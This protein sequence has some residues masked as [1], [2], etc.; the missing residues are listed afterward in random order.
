MWMVTMW[1][2]LIASELSI[3][4]KK[5]KSLQATEIS[6][7]IFLENKHMIQKMCGYFCIGFVDFMPKGKSLLKHTN[8]FSP[9]E[10]EKND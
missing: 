5:L 10:Y 3:F 6:Q 7:Q 9:D 2:I 8:L 1:H 4:Q